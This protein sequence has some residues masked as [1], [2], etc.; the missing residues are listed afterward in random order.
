M[1]EKKKKVVAKKV[2]SKTVAT[3]P[4]QKTVKSVKA[5]DKS[6]K[7]KKI[8]QTVRGM[9]DIL[10]QDGQLWRHL[11]AVAD[12]ISNSY[13]FEFVE[14]PILEEAALFVKTIGKNTDII[15]KE[16]YAF[17]DRDGSKLALRPE[18]TASIVRSYLNNGM[19][20][21]SQPVNMWYYGPMFRHE[22]PQAGR[23][24]QFHQ[25]GC[26]I[27]GNADAVADAQLIVM[28][29]NFF[30][31]L[32]INANVYINSIG[33]PEDRERYIVELVG[34]FR[35]KRS[36]LSEESKLRISKNP[37]RILDSKDP[38]DQEVVAEA[39]QIIDWLSEKSKT[40]FMKVLEYLDELDIP[41]VLKPTLVRGLDYYTDTVFEFFDVDSPEKSQS[42]LGG[43]GRYNLLIEELGGEATPATGFAIGLDRVALILKKKIETKEFTPNAGK[44][45]L[46]FAHLGDP[47][48]KRALFLIEELR[49]G[50][51]AVYHN[52][53]KP[54][55]K[56]QLEQA[57]KHDVSHAI[58]LGQKEMQD[59]TII[60]RDMSSGIQ[61]MVDQKKIV[62][63]IEKLQRNSQ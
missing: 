6:K 32:G 17:E 28:G 50:G 63:E 15:S 9:K 59:D 29:Y 26:E 23:Y 37:L 35:S 46:Y 13:N 42:A 8:P 54:S 48:K 53:G 60:I 10:P 12:N 36:Y 45:K 24:R 4:A 38:Q 52:F 61:E 34:Y 58:I 33:T 27:I 11:H 41:Y 2:T 30:R 51:I 19:I 22:R 56:A 3:K 5:E 16:M 39:P 31:D 40:Y 49:R 18:G 62:R 20:S 14:T 44:L 21:L 47:A 25:Y 7:I 43:G 1:P 57:N 55:L